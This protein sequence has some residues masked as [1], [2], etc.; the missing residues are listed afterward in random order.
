VSRGTATPTIAA[1]TPTGATVSTPLG[2]VVDTEKHGKTNPAKAPKDEA[3]TPLSA[4]SEGET[5]QNKK[6]DPPNGPKP[7]P[8]GNTGKVGHR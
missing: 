5:E 8:S 3:A 2:A 4:K 7:P 6:P 1:A